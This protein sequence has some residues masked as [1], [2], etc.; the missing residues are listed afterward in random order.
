M[1]SE[2]KSAAKIV[3]VKQLRRALREGSCSKVFLAENAEERITSP[4]AAI[5]RESGVEVEWTPT[6]AE[7]GHACGIEVG[8]AAAGILR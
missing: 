2:L 7:L 3:G 4:I 5:C 1:L 6:M 8:A